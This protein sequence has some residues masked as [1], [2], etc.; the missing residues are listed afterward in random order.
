MSFYYT[1]LIKYQ[2]GNSFHTGVEEETIGMLWKNVSFAEKAY[3]SIIEHYKNY[4]ESGS[5][6]RG[7][8]FDVENIKNK[9]WFLEDPQRTNKWED[10]WKFHINVKKDDNTDQTISAFWCGYFEKLIEIRIVSEEKEIF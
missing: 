6:I 8:N 10:F 4:K 9:E 3:R 5:T 2:T 7:R 1:I